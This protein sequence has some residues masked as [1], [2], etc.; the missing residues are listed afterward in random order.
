MRALLIGGTGGSSGAVPSNAAEKS[1]LGVV[2]GFEGRGVVAFLGLELERGVAA[3]F[4]FKGVPTPGLLAEV[5]IARF[6]V[7]MLGVVLGLDWGA[8]IGCFESRRLC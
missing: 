5:V 4:S 2:F 1:S 6:V 3:V 8:V 7:V